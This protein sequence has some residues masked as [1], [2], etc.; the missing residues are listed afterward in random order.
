MV[1]HWKFRRQSKCWLGES[2]YQG[3][4]HVRRK[5]AGVFCFKQLLD[6]VFR[7]I[8]NYQGRGK[9]YQPKPRAEADNTYR[10]LSFISY[11]DMTYH[12]PDLS[13]KQIVCK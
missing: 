2:R 13:F 6:E 4:G 7:D 1:K 10:D 3:R 12:A 5:L 8:R 11:H 9:C